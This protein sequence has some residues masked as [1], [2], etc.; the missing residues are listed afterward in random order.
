M[1][2]RGPWLSVVVTVVKK[3]EIDTPA[4]RQFL[5]QAADSFRSNLTKMQT[6]VE[7]VMPWKQNGER[8]HLG[9]KGFPPGKGRKWDPAVLARLLSTVKEVAPDVEVKWDVRD[10]ISIRPAGAA[11]MWVRVKTKEPGFVEAWLVGKPG[12]FNLSRVEGIGRDPE[13]DTDRTD[14]LDVLKLRFA[15]PDQLKPAEL[16]KLL[17]E[18]LSGFRQVAS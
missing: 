11:R 3:A 18:H 14:G 4:F 5:T 9:D 8:W 7:D 10:A 15:T 1:Q 2:D 12:Q 13:L 6:S 16:K 17:N